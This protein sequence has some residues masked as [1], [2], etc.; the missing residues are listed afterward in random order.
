MPTGNEMY[1]HLSGTSMATPHISGLAAL[2]WSYAHELGI[3]LLPEVVE[4]IICA[5]AYDEIPLTLPGYDEE[6]GWGR[7]NAAKAIRYFCYPNRI[8]IYTALW[9]TGN[10]QLTYYPYGNQIGVRDHWLYPD[11]LYECDQIKKLIIPLPT[12]SPA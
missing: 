8:D 1:H 11:G 6:Y 9:Q 7:I 4:G 3:P 5:S 12:P 10:P 2:I